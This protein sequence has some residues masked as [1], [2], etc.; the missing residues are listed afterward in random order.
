VTA[1]RV[2]GG[3][4]TVA[5]WLPSL[6]WLTTRRQWRQQTGALFVSLLLGLALT[7]ATRM[8]PEG[9]E[10]LYF[11]V[12][13]VLGMVVVVA[14]PLVLSTGSVLSSSR[15]ELLPVPP[16]TLWA[17][18][19]VLS[20]SFRTAATVITLAWGAF[21]VVTSGASVAVG[22]ARLL[23]LCAW[24]FLA[25]A[26]SQLLEDIIRYRRAVVVHQMAFLVG[27]SLWPYLL[28]Y[29]RDPTNFNPPPAW[30]TGPTAL[31]LLLG[32]G[33]P[34]AIIGAAVLPGLAAVALVAADEWFLA[35]FRA[36]PAPPPSSAR[37]TAAIAG[38]LA[39]G[40]DENRA[41]FK[42]ILVPLRFLFLRMSLVFI[43]LVTAAALSTGLP[44]LLLSIAF[45]WQP[46]STN[47]LGPDVGGGDL[48]YALM[49]KKA[50]HVLKYRLAASVLLTCAVVAPAALALVAL[51]WAEPP[52]VEPR[53]PLMYPLVFGYTL[54][55]L[56][57]WAVAGDRYSTRYPDALEMHTLLPER[58]RSAGAGAFLLLVALW[59]VTVTLAGIGIALGVAAVALV[60][61]LRFD[62]RAAAG[63]ATVAA[64]FNLLV[65][66][67]HLRSMEGRARAA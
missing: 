65:Y 40:R 18:R 54:S 39:L 53:S 33:S 30:A 57:L 56:A 5:D 44:Y 55:L 36:R 25:L 50:E 9:G 4:S 45:W 46:L 62:I 17:A 35:R 37:W 13:L 3:R 21:V 11:S 23:Y 52:S 22:G 16:T 51:G 31:F 14:A 60:S 28:Q 10:P 24:L 20:N 27:I 7:I 48:R 63:V 6:W 43:V 42:E 34:L 67:L 29:L 38:A 66:R 2:G 49:G 19:I 26:V 12:L 58:R 8:T 61:D 59:L 32:P 15:L 64:C 47:A 41:L 1:G